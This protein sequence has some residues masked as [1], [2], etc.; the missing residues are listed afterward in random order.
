MHTAKRRSIP[1]TAIRIDPPF[2]KKGPEN[3]RFVSTPQI[4][5]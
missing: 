4:R 1:D 2:P 5:R 3:M